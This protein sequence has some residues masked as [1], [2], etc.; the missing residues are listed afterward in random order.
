MKFHISETAYA[1]DN[2]KACF[3]MYN[4]YLK[5]KEPN[6]INKMNCL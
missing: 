1:K 5:E 3:K 4:F 2:F 6:F